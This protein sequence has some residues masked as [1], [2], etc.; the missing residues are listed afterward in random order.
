MNVDR[1]RF[2]QLA[3]AIAATTTTTVACT[4]ATNDDATGESEVQAQTVGGACNAQSIK[5]PGEGSMTPYAYEEGF[6][7]DLAR[8][9][10]APDAEG[11]ST[12]FFDFVYDQCR[13]YSSQLQPAVA[14]KVKACLDDADRARPHDADGNPR[15]EFDAGKM[16][17]CGKNALWSICSDGIDARVNSGGRCDRIAD[18]LKRPGV[19]GY[20]PADRRPTQSIVTECMAV[21]SGLKTSARTQIEQCVMNEGWDI[22]TCVEGLEADFTLSEGG[23][24]APSAAEACSAPTAASAPAASA[25]D[26]VLAKARS[27]GEFYVP[28]FTMHR[29]NVYVNKLQ[30]AAAKAAIDCLLD[31]AKKT[32]DNIYACGTLGLK[33]VCRDPGAVDATCKGIVDSI[34]A[35][36]PQANAGGRLTRQCRTMLPGLKPAA[37]DEI[38]RCV[39]GLARSFHESQI[40]A[41]Y[42][43][44]SCVEGLDP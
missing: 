32:Y 27:E 5:R 6:C 34:V 29:C 11:V 15:E 13:M 39:P 43:L 41:E 18:A 12:H 20:R 40:G 19:N 4:A 23:E 2:L 10:G 35:I 33:K 37:R 14:K 30:P 8:W 26:R 38:K 24:P 9:E 44:Y 31:P 16:Y 3:F 28:E 25:C 17:E 7:F 1:S 42:S 36:D 21:L 22:Y